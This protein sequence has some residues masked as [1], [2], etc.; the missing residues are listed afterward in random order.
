[1]ISLRGVMAILFGIAALAWP[2]LPVIVLVTL[3]GAYAIV[4][5]VVAI[6]SVV[7]HRERA[8]WWAVLLEGLLGILAGIATFAW[9]GITA[10]V[11]VVLIGAWA[12][13]T[14][15]MEVVAAF[16]LRREMEDEWLLGLAG[17]LSIV[18]GGALIL[19]PGPGALALAWLIGSYA[20]VFGI[21]LLLLGLRLR[22]GGGV[23]GLAV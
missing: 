10:I 17:I 18:V 13:A 16:R 19:L 4:D 1:M 6:V 5:G 23:A 22:Q 15:V 3:F 11:L 8:R 20:I 21:A 9:P 12:I 14:G 2:R 7:R